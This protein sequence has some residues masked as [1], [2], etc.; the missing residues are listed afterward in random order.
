MNGQ[1]DRMDSPPNILLFSGVTPSKAT[2][3]NSL[4][5]ALTSAAT[6]VVK[7]LK[8]TPDPP[9]QAGSSKSE[10]MSPTKRAHVSGAYLDHLDK[11]KRLLESGVLSQQEFEEQKG[12]VLD[13]IRSLNS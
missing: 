9:Q 10:T 8:G 13:N 12:F 7:M 1:H 4:N 2:N 6:A 5:E 3:S 11:L